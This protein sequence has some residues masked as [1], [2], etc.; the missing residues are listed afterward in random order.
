MG[1]FISDCPCGQPFP[2]SCATS[3]T[4]W[5]CP[6]CGSLCPFG[7]I[8]KPALTMA[9][10]SSA[11]IKRRDHRGAEVM[12]G[13]RVAYNWSG[14]IAMGIVARITASGTIF[15]DREWPPPS[16]KVNLSKVLRSTS[17]MV[18]N[19]SCPE[20]N[21]EPALWHA[22]TCSRIDANP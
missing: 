8:P 7:L 4:Q 3:G 1:A 22:E 13:D 17:V 21:S 9:S 14:D 18:I 11:R 12:V 6:S 15:I 20:C 5:V 19:E 16:G 2:G 10:S